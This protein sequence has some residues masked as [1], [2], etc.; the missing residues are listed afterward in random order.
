MALIVALIYAILLMMQFT[1]MNVEFKDTCTGFYNMPC[2]IYYSR[3]DDL[4]DN[5]YSSTLIAFVVLG[6]M[7]T[8]YKWVS[9]GMLRKKMNL[10]ADK[11][12]AYSCIMLNLWDFRTAKTNF[13][14]R[15]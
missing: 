2:F 6:L 11:K 1:T 13:D 8:I 15:Q 9:F 5:Y 7:I 3:F 10:Y 4:T 12:H 14:C